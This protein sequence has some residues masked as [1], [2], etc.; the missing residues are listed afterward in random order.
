M[1]DKSHI[2]TLEA[3]L[4]EVW[5]ADAGPELDRRFTAGVMRAVR[6]EAAERRT[7]AGPSVERLVRGALLAALAA[8][9]A[10][11]AVVLLRAGSLDPSLELARVMASDPQGLLQLVLVL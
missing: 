9:A 2:D 4:A 6:A 10:A 5:R 8:A 11:M 7:A 1:R 3:R